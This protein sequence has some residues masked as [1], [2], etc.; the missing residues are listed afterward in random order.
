MRF[1]LWKVLKLTIFIALVIVFNV[2]LIIY[3]DGENYIHRRAFGDS[4]EAYGSKYG[5]N[6]A[7]PVDTNMGAQPNSVRDFRRGQRSA[8]STPNDRIGF[9]GAKIARRNGLSLLA[10]KNIKTHNKYRKETT[11]TDVFISV[12]TTKKFHQSRVMLQLKTWF[13]LARDV[14][15]VR[16]I[17]KDN[18]D[19]DMEK[20]KQTPV[21]KLV[22]KIS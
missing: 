3:R 8:K 15:S 22:I 18:N 9:V 6:K 13:M 17:F 5:V 16:I 14:V 10:T 11:L 1:S 2:L 21:N 20:T 7:K 19:D 4:F 12:K